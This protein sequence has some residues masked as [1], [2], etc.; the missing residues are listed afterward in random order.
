MDTF[1]P[2][3]HLTASSRDSANR[4]YRLATLTIGLAIVA[5]FLGCGIVQSAPT[6]LVSQAAV[7]GTVHGGQQPVSGSV[8]SLIAP[9]TTGYGTAG[10]VIVSTVSDLNGGFTL[11]RPYTCPANSGLVYLLA[12]GGNAGAG[13]NPFI[14]EAAIVGDCNALTASTFVNISEVTTVTAAYALAPF[15]TVTPGST[16]I[17]TSATNLRG[18]YNAAGPANN[19]VS[20]ASG[21]AHATGD[22]PGIVVPTAEINTLADILASCVNQGTSSVPSGTCATLFSAA[23][24]PSGPAPTDTFQAAIDIALHPGNHTAALFGLVTAAPPFQP[25]LATAPP[26]FS[27]ALGFNGGGITLGGGAIGVA[28]DANGN[29]WITTGVSDPSVHSLTEISPA[30][31]YLS[32]STVAASTG[33]D[34]SIISRGIGIAIDQSGFIYVANNTPN[35]VLKFNSD[36]SLNSTLTA[37]SLSGPNGIATDAAGNIWVA[38]FNSTINHVTEITTAGAEAALSPYATGNGGVD[39]A[40]GPLAIWETDFASHL[41]SRIDLTS[42]A[43]TNIGIGGPSGGIAIDHANNAWVAVTGNGNVFEINNAGAFVSPNGGF[44]YPN[45]SVQNITIDGLGNAFAGGYLSNTSMGGLVEFS[46][47]GVLLSPNNGFSGSNVIPVVPEPPEGI[48]IDGSGN[49][50]IV[51]S[52]NGTALPNYVAEVIGI[53]APVV[54]PRGLAVANNTLGVRP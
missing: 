53:A 13:I 49:V 33:F 18:L 6:P 9:G 5:P 4:V 47:S 23:T 15:A 20:Y 14:A 39:I 28:I 17:G 7:T 45:G 54:T 25:A 11:P 27:V 30:G 1:L 34:S 35:N 8:V 42:F 38:D 46:N 10:T 3:V 37:A 24:P 40:A 51:G 31:V 16:A 50:W 36:G 29:A 43:V 22:F 52:N 44:V 12:T 26:D 32:G 41:V 2:A 48:H 19:L 21:F